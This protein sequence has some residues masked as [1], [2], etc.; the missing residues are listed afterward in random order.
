MKTNL[1]SCLALLAMSVLSMAQNLN[2][3]LYTFPDV[4]ALMPGSTTSNFTSQPTAL[5]LNRAN[6]LA[7]IIDATCTNGT[8]AASGLGCKFDLSADGT[9]WT[10]TLPLTNSVTMNGTNRVVGYTLFAP[11]VL[12]HM[13][14]IRLAQ[15]VNANTN[16]I[17][18]NSIKASQFS[19]FR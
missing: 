10:T 15:I 5:K 17:T 3:V 14:Y 2:P 13:R 7:I 8:T 1:L 4:G 16:I 6:G 12:D 9:T 19:P 18:I 11:S